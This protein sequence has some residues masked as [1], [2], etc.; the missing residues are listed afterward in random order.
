MTKLQRLQQEANAAVKA[1]RDVAE[2]ASAAQRSMT[3]DEQKTYDESMAKGRELLEQIKTA[4]ADEQVL[5]DAKALADE[6]GLSPEVKEDLDAQRELPT[7]E[8]A[9]NLGLQIVGSDAFK[10]MIG[11]FPDGRIPEKSR[12]QSDP[13][14]VKSLIRSKSLFT[15]ASDTSRRDV[16]GQRPVRHPGDARPSR[17]SRLRDLVSVRRTG[18][19][20]VEYV[21][22]TSHTNNAA[23]VAEATTSAAPTIV[24]T[25]GTPNVSVVTRAAGG[26]YKPEGAWAFERDVTR[27]Q[28]HRR[29]GAL[30]PSGP[31]PTSPPARGPHQR[32]ARRTDIEEVE[33]ERDPQRLRHAASTS[34]A[35]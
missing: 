20:T 16:R 21:R 15:G 12:I 23:P 29:V 25:E 8:R 18:S 10:A 35:S 4:K 34:P 7:R 3:A 27:R 26:G 30:P 13:I 33:D 14:S 28:D 31:S 24:N 9:K 11:A 1:A 19:D 32:R 2:V 17:P 6:I 5:A 22:Q